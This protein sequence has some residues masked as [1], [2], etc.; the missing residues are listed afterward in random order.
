LVG[1]FGGPGENTTFSINTVIGTQPTVVPRQ[2]NI[3]KKAK[4]SM[5]LPERF[6]QMLHPHKGQPPLYLVSQY[7]MNN[8]GAFL[9][10]VAWCGLEYGAVQLKV[11]T[12][13]EDGS[14][15]PRT[16]A[17]TIRKTREFVF[18]GRLQNL[19]PQGPEGSQAY[20][21]DWTQIPKSQMVKEAGIFL[22]EEFLKDNTTWEEHDSCA[23]WALE[24]EG[25]AKRDKLYG[26]NAKRRRWQC[27]FI[28]PSLK[29]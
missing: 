24:N 18:E 15:W 13:E 14:W 9:E 28:R 6:G 8:F 5:A 29:G 11:P 19:L 4:I 21:L 3:L 2:V 20:K 7:A 17:G 23:L 10:A 27:L 16:K 25:R 22:W 12:I 1:V 26:V